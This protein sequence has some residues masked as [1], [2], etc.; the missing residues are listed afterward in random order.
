MECYVLLL[1][2]C[3]LPIWTSMINTWQLAVNTDTHTHTHTHTTVGGY[4]NFVGDHQG[5]PIAP[6]NS[7]HETH[8]MVRTSGDSTALK[9][10]ATIVICIFYCCSFTLIHIIMTSSWHHHD[11][12][13]LRQTY[14]L[15][16]TWR[17]RMTAG[18]WL[19]AKPWKQLFIKCPY[20]EI[21]D[22]TGVTGL[23][24][25]GNVVP[26]DGTTVKWSQRK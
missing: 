19:M 14:S 25:A 21:N 22:P 16:S 23:F 24:I 8:I 13:V 2:I 4:G 20:I 18:M 17:H 3:L 10:L 7:L 12:L 15:R 6:K 5:W 9:T 1:T 26:Q 11:V